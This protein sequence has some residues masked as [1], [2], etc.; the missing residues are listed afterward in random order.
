MN[1][2]EVVQ[3]SMNEY[4]EKDGVRFSIVGECFYKDEQNGKELFITN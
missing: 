1:S 4:I 2:S 3:S